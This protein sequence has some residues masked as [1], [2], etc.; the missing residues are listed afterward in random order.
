MLERASLLESFV[1]NKFI[2]DWYHNTYLIFFTALNSWLVA[3]LGGGIGWLFI[4]L[5]F[6]ATVYGTSIRRLRQRVSDELVREAALRRIDKE[7]ETLEWLNSFL[8]KF[9]AIYEP[10]L[11]E[12]IVTQVNPILASSTPAMIEGLSLDTFTLGTKPPRIEFVQSHPRTES[13]VVVMD[14]KAS[15]TPNDVQDRTAR[16]LKEK[17]S[18]KV[19]L[20]IRIGKGAISKKIKVAVEDMMFE[21]TLNFRMKL[22]PNFPHVKTLDVSFLEPPKFDFSLKPLMGADLTLI[23]GL[24]GIIHSITDDNLG[25]MM[26]APNS[27]QINIEEM[28][29]ASGVDSAIGVLAVSVFNASGL[30]GSD[31]IGNT[32]DPYAVFSLNQNTELARTKTVR[33]TKNPNWNETKYIL[34]NNLSEVLNIDFFDQN[35]RRKDK[36][37]GNLSI[38][39]DTLEAKPD[40]ENLSGEIQDSGK[41]RGTVNYELHWF[42]AMEGRKLEDGTIEPPPDTKT[43][44]LKLWVH[45]AK[46]LDATKSMV[47]QLSPYSDML[48]NGNLIHQSKSVKRIN[49]PVWEDN[50][51]F[52][53]TDKTNCNLGIRIKDSRGL[54]HDPVLG[55]YQIKLPK[56]LD[57]LAKGEDW[58]NLTPMGRVRLSAT[59][60]PVSLKGGDALRNYV[61][62]IGALRFHFIK[63]VDVMN[64]ETIG[65]VDPYL[66]VFFN[67]FQR[68]RT[69]AIDDT[70]DPVWDEVIYVPVQASGHRISIEAMDAEN[71]GKDKTLGHFFLDSADFIKTDDKGNYLPY[72]D[73]Q[74]RTSMFTMGKKDPKGTLHYTVSFYPSVRVMN[75]D[76]AKEKAEKAQK[77]AEEKNKAEASGEK[78]EKDKDSDA[79]TLAES[80]SKNP[81]EELPVIPLEQL[82]KSESGVLAITFLDT[83]VKESDTWIRILSDAHVNPSFATPRIQNKTQTIGETGEVTVL[84]LDFSVLNFELISKLNKPRSDDILGKCHIPSLALLKN[85]YDKPFTLQFKRGETVTGSLV[86][87]VRYFPLMMEL[88]PSESINNMG[89]LTTE[90]IKADNV[91]AAD[92]SGYSDPYCNVILNGEKIF[93]TEKQKKT[94]NPVWNESFTADIISRTAADMSIEVFD[95]DMGSDDDFLGKVK[96]DLAQLEPLK[97]IQLTLPLQGESG[98]ITLRFMFRPSYVMRRV[99]SSGVGA[100]FIQ[101]AALPGK[102]VAGVAGKGVH[103]VGG[104]AKGG[105]NVVGGVAGGALGVVKG[106]TSKFAGA[107]RSKKNK[108][109]GSSS[110]SPDLSAET[111]DASLSHSYNNAPVVSS[112]GSIVGAGAGAGGMLGVNSPG[113]SNHAKSASIISNDEATSIMPGNIAGQFI[114]V[115][116]SNYTSSHLQVKAFVDKKEILKTKAYKTGSDGALVKI[117]EV[118]SF[119]AQSEA[120][121]LIK[122][123]EHKLIGRSEE[124]GEASVPLNA[125]EP[126]KP[127]A[128]TIGPG[129]LNV[130]VNLRS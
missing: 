55:T 100:S 9:W 101:G 41:P 122:V 4:V 98:T 71:V 116:A 114:V 79:T 127:M 42:P 102:V 110:Q 22:I 32:V 94:L 58:Y 11:C 30:K 124:L 45:Q 28:M 73:T 53:V 61:E 112:D 113:G 84:E 13:D 129:Q 2:G 21:G 109:S 78:S 115:S 6:S 33:N 72:V 16:Q 76:E 47:G 29:A 60:K 36:L 66:R 7:R 111:S 107:F 123:Y 82:I 105:A 69:V 50:F 64:L 43:G 118:S 24:D 67:G 70:L 83:Q 40:Q 121:V 126:N 86:V 120:Q 15:F 91:P 26:Y 99:D 92:R 48:I 89:S 74:V 62:P 80:D 1:K 95:W 19:V 3:W 8:V 35:D 130:Q 85:A 97:P 10:A 108:E 12:M 87:R 18:P 17:V 119:K 44:I 56:L 68:G 39:L 103:A 25:P 52:L 104:V 37:I 46:D 128:V 57:N 14:W 23:P 65:K 63:A 93:K 49:N 34:V 27:F 117:E 38:P 59:W 106:G 125:F 5:A 51:E 81:E 75:P 96:I 54:A 90:I 20:G 31:S 77:E 88:D